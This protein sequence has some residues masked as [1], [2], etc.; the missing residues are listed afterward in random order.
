MKQIWLLGM[1]LTLALS[2]VASAADSPTFSDEVVRIVQERCQTCHRPGEHAP[3]SLITYADVF[4][5]RADIRD[6][7]DWR[8]MPPWKPVPGFGSFLESR[9]LSDEERATILK[10]IDA[11]AK[12]GP[13]IQ[14]ST[15]NPTGVPDIKPRV[16]VKPQIG[17]IAYR[18]D[19]KLLALGTY[20]EVR[21][22]D[23]AG[24]I[25]GALTGHKEQVRA[26]A[27]SPDGALL[28]AAGGQPGRKGEVKIWDVEKRSVIRTIE[29]HADCIYAVAFSPDGKTL[30]GA[31]RT[32][33]RVWDV[34]TGK[35][36]Q[37]SDLKT[38]FSKKA[39]SALALSPDGRSLAV[40]G[41]QDDKHVIAL[42]DVKTAKRTKTLEGHAEFLFPL[43]F[44][45]D[46]NTLAGAGLETIYLWDFDQGTK[47]SKGSVAVSPWQG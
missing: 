38:G 37:A 23:P 21:L 20:K 36:I 46:G 28:A 12:A 24:K 16:A 15:L 33:L 26:V 40:S 41:K 29:G 13:P 42:Y 9:R 19:G 5:R 32:K 6:Q 44:T 31:G 17:A 27:F 39:L 35:T 47:L 22:A 25:L 11:G 3:F 7:I 18:P 4:T 34:T 10:W 14:I 1:V 43:S 2:G 45:S 30:V 8:T